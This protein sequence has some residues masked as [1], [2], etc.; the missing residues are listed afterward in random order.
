MRT[1]Y[2]VSILKVRKSKRR[3]PKNLEIPW[4]V[5]TIV[6]LHVG[7]IGTNLHIRL[8]RPAHSVTYSPAEYL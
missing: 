7:N 5:N 8:L 4:T 2:M 1:L 6:Y 3:L